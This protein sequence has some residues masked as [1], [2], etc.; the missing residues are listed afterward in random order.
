MQAIRSSIYYEMYFYC[1]R[2]EKFS[3]VNKIEA[4]PG[5]NKDIPLDTFFNYFALS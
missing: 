5:D 1:Q 4:T 2:V 3:E